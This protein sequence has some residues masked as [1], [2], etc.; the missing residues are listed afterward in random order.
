MPYR[1]KNRLAMKLVSDRIVEL[2]KNH[3]R[4]ICFEKTGTPHVKLPRKTGFAQK[5]PL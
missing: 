4:I 3:R 2:G 5:R 1:C